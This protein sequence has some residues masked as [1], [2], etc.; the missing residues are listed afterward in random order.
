MPTATLL[1]A[2]TLLDAA[3]LS[4][5]EPTLRGI[6]RWASPPAVLPLPSAATAAAD[7]SVGNMIFRTSCDGVAQG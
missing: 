2:A 3:P 6:R 4:Q 7:P 1:A 5:A